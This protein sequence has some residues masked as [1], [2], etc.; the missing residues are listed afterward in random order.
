MNTDV[1]VLERENYC[2]LSC[3]LARAASCNTHQTTDTLNACNMQH[4]V[5]KDRI[6]LTD[7]QH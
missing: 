4:E 3:Y 6:G 1:A 7:L 2:R 5:S